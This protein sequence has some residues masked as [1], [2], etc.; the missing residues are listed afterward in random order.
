MISAIVIK[1]TTG[2]YHVVTTLTFSRYNL[3]IFNIIKTQKQ[4]NEVRFFNL[5]ESCLHI[6]TSGGY[7]STMASEFPLNISLAVALYAA[8]DC[9][10]CERTASIKSIPSSIVVPIIIGLF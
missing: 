4:I 5:L 1:K 7:C 8:C 10:G 3:I 2:R 6:L 9:S